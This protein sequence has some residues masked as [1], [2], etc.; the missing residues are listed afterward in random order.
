MGETCAR[1]EVLASGSH[2]P[3]HCDQAHVT[4]CHVSPLLPRHTMLE[5][6]DTKPSSTEAR[7]EDIPPA[8]SVNQ[9]RSKFTV[10]RSR[11]APEVRR[12]PAA[13]L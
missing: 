1:E 13:A 4:I 7:S 11:V 9:L 3:P 6:S 5:K 10:G 12:L 8:I 2:D